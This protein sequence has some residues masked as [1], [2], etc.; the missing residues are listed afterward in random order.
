[1]E[2]VVLASFIHDQMY[3]QTVISH[4]KSDFF[5]D[6]A[7]KVLFNCAIEYSEEHKTTP[8]KIVLETILDSKLG[9]PESI[10]QKSKI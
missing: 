5:E 2:K 6:E 10:Y 4:I 7:N 3:N 1:M 8:P 9:I